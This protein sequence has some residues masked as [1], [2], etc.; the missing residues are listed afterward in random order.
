MHDDFRNFQRRPALIIRTR[1]RRRRC[2][3]A[4]RIVINSAREAPRAVQFR[5]KYAED[6]RNE[7]CIRIVSI[8]KSFSRLQCVKLAAA[9]IPLSRQGSRENSKRGVH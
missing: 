5:N 2:G 6:S 8:L 9:G 3:P 4:T 1:R 7:R